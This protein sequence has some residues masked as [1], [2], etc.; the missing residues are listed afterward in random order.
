MPEHRILTEARL[1]AIKK[2]GS[3]LSVN[4]ANS[5]V[6]LS[7]R[8]T[9]GHEWLAL[10][11]GI[12]RGGWCPA[13]SGVKRKTPEDIDRLA[14]SHGGICLNSA[15]YKNIR[16]KNM[17]FMCSKKHVFTTTVNVANRHWCPFCTGLA[18]LTIEEVRALVNKLGGECLEDKYINVRT[19]MRF[20]CKES[21]VFAMVFSSVKSGAWCPDCAGNRKHSLEDMR[22]F[23]EGRG[24][25]CLSELYS[26]GLTKLEWECKE[27]HRFRLCFS[28][29]K[30]RGSWCPRCSGKRR[31]DFSDVKDEVA[32]RGG[33]CLCEKYINCYTKFGVRCAS[34]HIFYAH[35]SSIKRGYWCPRC[36]PH[37][38]EDKCREIFESILSV[39]FAP[40]WP[41]WLKN[42]AGNIME[43]DGYNEDLKLAF[44]YNGIQHYK[45]F[46]RYHRGVNTLERRVK[47]DRRKRYLCKKNNVKL[48]IIPYTIPYYGIELYI[49]NRLKEVLDVR[50]EI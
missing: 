32:K 5:S 20:R 27:G 38:N 46:P 35:M 40:A 13:R 39:S 10:I 31:L 36:K 22:I 12:R 50:Q 47:D 23:A 41:K 7:W 42:S 19:K 28:S 29:A 48:I 49:S 44:E 25:K 17:K 43:L 26:G 16:T 30:H 37:Y 18:R 34:G 45:Y 6:K 24:G 9:K 2:G 14:E 33:E 1:L 11:N 3:C 8:C 4:Y 21:H 15:E